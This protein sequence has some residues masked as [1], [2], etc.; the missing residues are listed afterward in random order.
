MNAIK[1][2]RRLA[3]Q[4]TARITL[5]TIVMGAILVILGGI[6]VILLWTTSSTISPVMIRAT[7][8][9]LGVWAPLA[10][11]LALAGVLVVPLIPASVLQIGAGLAFGPFLGLAYVVVADILGA[12]I[13]FALARYWGKSLLARVL[14]PETQ[15]NLAGITE[16]ISWRGVILLRLLPGPVY[17]LVSLAA[18]YAS[19]RYSQYITASL[20]GVL[21]GLALLVLAGDLAAS[22]PLLAFAVVVLLIVG[23]VV[24]S[25]LVS[26]KPASAKDMDRK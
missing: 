22:S 6:G 5:R 7:L 24:L 23:L 3:T 8:A 13:G 25:R 18:G 2:L 12:S 20:L 17:P 21:P 9:D 15:I 16:R 11:I 14:S 19:L 10:L 4:L 1:S 26:V